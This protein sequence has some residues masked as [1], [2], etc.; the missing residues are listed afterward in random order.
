M[1]WVGWLNTYQLHQNSNDNSLIYWQISYFTRVLMQIFPQILKPSPFHFSLFF[2]L[3]LFEGVTSV[4]SLSLSLLLTPPAVPRRTHCRHTLLQL[5]SPPPP[6]SL[7]RLFGHRDRGRL[8]LLR[9]EKSRLFPSMTIE[10]LILGKK[11]L[12]GFPAIMDCVSSL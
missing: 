9:L 8:S 12:F 3:P 4:L 10:C 11:F 1:C 2:L 5:G 6:P 7:S